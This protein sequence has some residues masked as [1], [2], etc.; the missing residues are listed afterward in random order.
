[1]DSKSIIESQVKALEKEFNSATFDD[2]LCKEKNYLTT[3]EAVNR[4]QGLSNI[5]YTLLLALHEGDEYLGYTEITFQLAAKNDNLFLDFQGT[6]LIFCFLNGTAAPLKEIFGRRRIQIPSKYQKTGINTIKLAFRNQ[7]ATDGKGLHSFVDP[8]DSQQYLYTYFE[9]F[10]AN[11]MF[12]CFD[13]PSL[14]ASLKLFTVSP[15]HWT[16]IANEPELSSAP[17]NEEIQFPSSMITKELIESKYQIKAFKP[18]PTISTYLFACIAGPYECIVSTNKSFPAMR[19]FMRKSLRRFVEP[20][21]KEFFRVTECGIRFYEEIAGCT[22]PF[23]KYDQIY[24]PESNISAVENVGAVTF[25]E[26]YVFKDPPTFEKLRRIYEIVLHELSHM[27]FG[28]LVAVKWWN[29]LWLKESFATFIANLCIA[30]A[31][32]LEAYHSIWTIFCKKK[33][34]AYDLDQQPTT[35]PIAATISNIEEVE[36]L[37]DSITYRKGASVLK[38]LYHLI[39]HDVFCEGLKEYFK[40][41]RWKNTELKDFVRAMQTAVKEDINLEQWIEQWLF[42]KGVNE[43][44]PIV[45]EENGVV[46]AFKVR[47]SVAVNGDNVNR[48]HVIDIGL[49]DEDFKVKVVERVVI[50][51]KQETVIEKLKGISS[52]MYSALIPVSYTHLTLPTNREV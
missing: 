47:Q 27:W 36:N 12:P 6:S 3:V 40:Q 38:Q 19:L 39:A 5:N 51:P 46:K 17:L 23:D 42:T 34:L 35:H 48:M 16:V 28:N 1:M 26:R 52:P 31:P 22:F 33:R 21:A 29:E 4:A 7:Y 45:E 32:G 37:F 49:Y 18:T 41:H 13:Q 43:L 2:P 10:D 25:T 50:E 14:R 30:K 20:R 15:S 44:E 8:E 11:R 24:C 9:P